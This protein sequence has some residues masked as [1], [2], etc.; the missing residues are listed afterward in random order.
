[1]QEVVLIGAPTDIGACALGAS[2]GPDALLRAKVKQKRFRDG[3]E[4]GLSTTHR[5]TS[6]AGALPLPA[7]GGRAATR[8]AELLG[9]LGHSLTLGNGCASVGR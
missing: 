6:A 4:E 5:A 8:A 7:D 3:Y 2:L 9:G 1:M